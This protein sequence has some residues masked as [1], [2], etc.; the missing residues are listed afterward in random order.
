VQVVAVTA[1]KLDLTVDLPGELIPYESVAIYPKTTGFVT[2]IR[3]DRG[4]RVR[5]D[6]LLVELEAPELVAQH[7][8]AESKL[9]AAQSALIA[10]QAK[11]AADQA[12]YERLLAAA[13]TP[14]VVSGND[15]NLAARVAEADRANVA[16]AQDG[17]KA[18]DAARNAIEQIEAYLRITAPF[19]G[20]IAERNVHPGALVGPASG[21]G[22]TVPMLRIQTMARL[23]LVVPVPENSVADVPTGARVKFTVPAYPTEVFQAP[24]ARVSHAIDP[25]TRTMP[26]E[27]DVTNAAGR[28]TPGTFCQVQWP[29][30]RSYATHFVPPTAVAT[31]QERTFVI[32]VPSQGSNAGKADWVDVRTGNTEGSLVEVFGDLQDGDQ[33]VLRA[34]DAIR[35][36]VQINP[37][38][39][40]SDR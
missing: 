36:G 17:V 15:L 37:V 14:G 24:V 20:V 18:A 4:S 13:K 39:T 19:D 1:Q 8:E 32:R 28:L 29:V 35:S 21:A 25:K 26:V 6:D 30:Q 9:A 5:K 27:L 3:V 23:R 40:S 10:V 2:S 12:T 31:N 38:Q 16:A 34:S 7:S 11:L 22:A 33:V